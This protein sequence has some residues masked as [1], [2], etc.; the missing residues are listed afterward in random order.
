MADPP[1]LGPVL[2]PPHEPPR[3]AI[4]VITPQNA[5]LT[6]SLMQSV[7]QF[8]TGVAAQVLHRVDLAGKTGT[9]N[10][11]INGWFGGFDP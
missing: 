9:T 8:G 2:M 1:H 11:Y 6:T 3:A 4:R 7:I 10:N 5:Y